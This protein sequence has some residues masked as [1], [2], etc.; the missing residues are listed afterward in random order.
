MRLIEAGG[1]DAG[2]DDVAEGD[3]EAGAE[4][5]ADGAVRTGDA[6]VE[7]VVREAAVGCGGEAGGAEEI[8]CSRSGGDGKGQRR[9][10]EIVETGAGDVGGGDEREGIV[11][12]F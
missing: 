2:G 6:G 1:G 4:G 10:G 5:V 7:A 11:S 8:F 12:F 3:A 9:V